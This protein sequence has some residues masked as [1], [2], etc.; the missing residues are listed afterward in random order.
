MKRK[1]KTSVSALAMTAMIMGG[2]TAAT[3]IAA[4]AFAKND[5]VNSEN[6]NNGNGNSASSNRGGV[7]SSN[8]RGATASSLGALNAAHANANALEHASE[9]SLVGMITLYKIAV[10]NTS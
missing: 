9:N 5:N 8:S 3:L 10:Q 2:I 4:P 1:I 6:S 7:G